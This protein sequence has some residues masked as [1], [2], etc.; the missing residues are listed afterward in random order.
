MT[1]DF[2][3]VTLPPLWTLDQ[4]KLHLRI[5]GTA[6]DADIAQKLATA[7]E[8]ILSYLNI[9]ADATWDATTA[10]AAVTHAIHMLTAYYYE[11]R[12]DG[13]IPDPWPKIYAL[14]AAYRDPT[15]A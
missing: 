7:Q 6:H 4:A 9:G 2:S 11:D 8:A 10:P 14:L 12:G 13:S 15:V 5:T 1:L 3:R